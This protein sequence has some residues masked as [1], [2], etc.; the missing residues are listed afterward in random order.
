MRMEQLRNPVAVVGLSAAAAFGAANME[1]SQAEASRE[2]PVPSAY[3]F[4]LQQARGAN[5][6]EGIA[7]NPATAVGFRFP[8]KEG[9]TQ[10]NL[11]RLV[12]E[13]VGNQIGKYCLDNVVNSRTTSVQV[14]F[15]GKNNRFKKVNVRPILFTSEDAYDQDIS[16]RLKMGYTGKDVLLK[17]ITNV[18]TKD[19]SNN[20]TCGLKRVTQTGLVSE[21]P[22]K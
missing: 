4:C 14:Y 18:K 10:P 8:S 13:G 21:G 16:T 3:E 17:V 12:V 2:V 5:N 20:V 19:L 15:Q 7:S 11:N 22:C 1:T 9:T 6:A